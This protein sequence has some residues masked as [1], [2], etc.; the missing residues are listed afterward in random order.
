MLIFYF[1]MVQG[2]YQIT[3][4]FGCKYN[5]IIDDFGNSQIIDFDDD[6]S[7][8]MILQNYIDIVEILQAKFNFTKSTLYTPQVYEDFN[9]IKSNLKLLKG[10]PPFILP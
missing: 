8:N 3:I 1:K 2:P 6:N 4:T 5:I 10:S 7:K 9:Q